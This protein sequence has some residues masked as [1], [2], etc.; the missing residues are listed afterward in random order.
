[1]KTTTFGQVHNQFGFFHKM[2]IFQNQ[3]ELEVCTGK[4]KVS[5]FPTHSISHAQSEPMYLKMHVIVFWQNSIFS[6]M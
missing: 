2:C 3:N 4:N 6:P 5:H 1:M